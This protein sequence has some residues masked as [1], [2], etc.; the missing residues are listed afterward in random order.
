MSVFF[1]DTYHINSR[2]ADPF[3]LCR[4]SS[5]MGYLQEAATGAAESGGFTREQLIRDHHVFW[6]LARIWYKLERPIP[7]DRKLTIRTWHRGNPGVMMYRD[8][9]LI[10]DGALIGE[11]VSVWVLA[12]IQTRKLSKM[13]IIPNLMVT[14]GG[15]LCK[16]KTLQKLRLP[17]DLPLAEVRR[18]HYSDTDINGHV[19]NS[20]YADLACDA[21]DPA[22]IG[23]R[24][25]VSSLQ[26][27][28]LGE[29]R[30]GEVLHIHAGPDEDGLWYIHGLDENGTARFDAAMT[31]C[32]LDNTG[33]IA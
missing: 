31:L 24:S 30:A 21:L 20:R 2:D 1:E 7:W 28:Y 11:A 6:M 29:C 15:E 18:L 19:N 17:P 5:L 27:G 32:P 22:Q 25:F 33:Y 14:S 13:S 10:L 4:P 23:K 16:G 3:G 9:D 26:L 8:F 12:D